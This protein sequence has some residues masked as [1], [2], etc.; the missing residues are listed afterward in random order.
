MTRFTFRNGNGKNA[1]MIN[2]G[3][4]TGKLAD[5]LAAFE[6][7]GLTP[8]E[9]KAAKQIASEFTPE[10][11][12]AIIGAHRA[13]RLVVLP[14]KDDLDNERFDSCPFCGGSNVNLIE[15]Y[16]RDLALNGERLYPKTVRCSSCG[17]E[18]RRFVSGNIPSGEMQKSMAVLWNT[19]VSS[20]TPVR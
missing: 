18:I 6:D 20:A 3:E 10:E 14:N 8:N 16:G 12:E 11:V 7:T 15:E 1:L 5:R 4:Y 17:A 9:I 19:R 13:G 2:G